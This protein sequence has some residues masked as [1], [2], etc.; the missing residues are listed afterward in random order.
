MRL[1]RFL[2]EVWPSRT[3]YEG[4]NPCVKQ[5]SLNFVLFWPGQDEAM[6]YEAADSAHVVEMI[7]WHMSKLLTERSRIP[8]KLL[9]LVGHW[10]RKHPLTWASAVKMTR[11]NVSVRMRK[12]PS[13]RSI[14]PSQHEKKLS[15][16]LSRYYPT[17]TLSMSARKWRHVSTT[18]FKSE[19]SLTL[20]NDW[21]D[22]LSFT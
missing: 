21:V 12:K 17:E 16:R 20:R 1:K 10:N 9:H 2:T 11:Q 4:R 7:S 8:P 22:F 13:I 18:D 15:C 19:S 6:L 14:R 3:Y 5:R